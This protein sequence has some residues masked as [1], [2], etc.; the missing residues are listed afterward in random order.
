MTWSQVF[1][2][3]GAMVAAIWAVFQWGLKGKLDGV[4]A[5]V[6]AILARLDKV[7]EHDRQITKITTTM[8]L[9]GCFEGKCRRQDR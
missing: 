7:D 5:V 2:F 1:T 6:D 3:V 4:K 8:E 9:N